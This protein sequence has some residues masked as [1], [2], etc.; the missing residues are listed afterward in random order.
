MDEDKPFTVRDRRKFTAEGERKSDEADQESPVTAAVPTEPIDATPPPARER[1][2]GGA[3]GVD[4]AGFIVSLA[5]QASVLL[6]TPEGDARENHRGAQHLIE[7]LEMLGDKTEGR[8]TEQEDQVLKQL[9]YELRMA[10]VERNRT[11]GE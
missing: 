8:R 3:G 4:F 1:A 6:S 9:L 2:Q 10:F 7:V 5:T 11:V